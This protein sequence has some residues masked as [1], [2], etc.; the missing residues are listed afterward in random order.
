MLLPNRLTLMQ[1]VQDAARHGFHGYF[2]GQVSREKWE[3]L[4]L[5][6]AREYD[7]DMPRSTRSKR[8]KAG[9]A[10]ALVYACPPPPW[11]P[12]GPIHFVLLATAGAGRIRAREQ[13]LELQKNRLELEGY[14]LVHDGVGWSWQMTAA[15]YRYWRERIHSA[16]ARPPAQRAF[17][18]EDG[19]QLDLHAEEILDALYHAP[20]FRL[21]RRQVGKLV[22]YLI[23]EWRRLRP[24]NEP[25][26]RPRGFL[27]YVRRL[28]NAKEGPD[29]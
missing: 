3:K 6:F 7:T 12:S 14:E 29:D 18:M 17:H 20:G 9:E 16:A 11:E 25:Q 28:P 24:A 22:A 21:V 8:R 5:K 26:P 2:V 27:P 4:S 10:V 1:R 19:L 13:L 15:R 23:S